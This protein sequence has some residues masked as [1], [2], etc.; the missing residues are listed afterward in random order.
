M[1]FGNYVLFNLLVAILVEGFSSEVKKKLLW[2]YAV[3]ADTLRITV[4]TLFIFATND[5]DAK[6]QITVVV[7]AYSWVDF[8]YV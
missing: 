5:R 6:L 7:A 2:I 8:K 1:T 4:E 3:R